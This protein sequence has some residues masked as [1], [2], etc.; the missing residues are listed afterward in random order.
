MRQTTITRIEGGQRPLRLQEAEVL[1]IL[2]QVPIASLTSAPG[3]QLD[4]VTNARALLRERAELEEEVVAA[5]HRYDRVRRLLIA[6]RALVDINQRREPP[7]WYVED[8]EAAL[9]DPELADAIATAAQTDALEVARASLAQAEA[10]RGY[11]TVEFEDVAGRNPAQDVAAAE[12][13]GWEHG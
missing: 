10:M 6:S 2:L 11:R 12:R 4:F 9:V 5:A 3:P 1:S 8:G 13:E 7:P